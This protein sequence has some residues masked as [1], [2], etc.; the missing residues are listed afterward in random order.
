[1]KA[2]RLQ[3][4]GCTACACF[5]GLMFAGNWSVVG[6][7]LAIE[8]YLGLALLGLPLT[9]GAS[10][11]EFRRLGASFGSNRRRMFGF[12]L[13][14]LTVPYV[15]YVS[16]LGVWV[17]LDLQTPQLGTLAGQVVVFSVWAGHLLAFIFGFFGRGWGRVAVLLGTVCCFFVWN[18]PLDA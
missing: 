11:F 4:A 18:F 9:I 17:A 15:L 7:V 12:A 14:T 2:R 16:V 8:A 6:R 5:G 1:M 3:I 13:G 10:W